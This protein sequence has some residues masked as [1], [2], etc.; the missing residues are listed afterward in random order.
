MKEDCDL[1][2]PRLCCSN[3]GL[4]DCV[5]ADISGVCVCVVSVSLPNLN[6]RLESGGWLMNI[7]RTPD[8]ASPSAS[9]P[10]VAMHATGGLYEIQSWAKPVPRGVICYADIVLEKEAA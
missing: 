2:P 9:A 10:L 7:C 8:C 6:Y 3:S 4:I 5:V 1:T